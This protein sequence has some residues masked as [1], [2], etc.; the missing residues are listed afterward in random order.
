MNHGE[1]EGV[2]EAGVVGKECHEPQKAPRLW[3][4]LPLAI[5][6]VSLGNPIG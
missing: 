3:H 5:S 4:I 2:T 6:L 1:H